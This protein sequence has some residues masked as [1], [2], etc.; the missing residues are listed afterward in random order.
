[1]CWLVLSQ[2]LDHPVDPPNRQGIKTEGRQ[3]A[4]TLNRDGLGIET[5][6]QQLLVALNI[7][8]ELLAL[9]AHGYPQDQA[10]AGALSVID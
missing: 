3:L 2:F 9:I 6:P 8:F 1:M 5:E 7:V 10:G 4:G